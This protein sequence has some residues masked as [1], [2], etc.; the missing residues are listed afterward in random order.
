MPRRPCLDCGA[1]SARSRCPAHEAQAQA[2]RDA[3]RGNSAAR[4]YGHPHRAKRAA[5]L[6]GA[7]GR[8]CARCGELI[9][10]GQALDAGH[11]TALA[12][13]P[14]SQA[15]RIEHSDCNRRAGGATRRL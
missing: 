14:H 15:D 10:P 7:Y 4:G 9:L 12:H 5:M 8:P 11:S 2:R 3:A 6:P 1:L 13:D